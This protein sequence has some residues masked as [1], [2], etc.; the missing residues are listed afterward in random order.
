MTEQLSKAK[1]ETEQISPAQK[2][3]TQF[4]KMNNCIIYASFAAAI[5]LGRKCQTTECWEASPGYN[6]VWLFALAVM[7]GV[8]A[9][10][11]FVWLEDKEGKP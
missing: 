1:Q 4:K 3:R 7:V 10:T 2:R 9:E 6:F 8:I 5:Y 11:Y